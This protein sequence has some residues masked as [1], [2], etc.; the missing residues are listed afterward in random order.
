M[1]KVYAVRDGRVNHGLQFS[2]RLQAIQFVRRYVRL[3]G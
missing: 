2:T 3:M 1:V